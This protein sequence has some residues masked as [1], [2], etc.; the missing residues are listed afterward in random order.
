MCALQIDTEAAAEAAAAGEP[1][2]DADE[3]LTVSL[4]FRIY[5]GSLMA[6]IQPQWGRAVARGKS[7]WAPHGKCERATYGVT[8]GPP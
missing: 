6:S 8:G 4:Y 5:F 7:E 3:P 1:E 2:D